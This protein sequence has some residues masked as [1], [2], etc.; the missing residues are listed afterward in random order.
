VHT[1]APN[2]IPYIYIYTYTYPYISISIKND[3]NDEVLK[4]SVIT[5]VLKH[6]GA[7]K[8]KKN[9]EVLKH[10]V[11]HVLGDVQVDIGPVH[12]LLLLVVPPDVR[13]SGGVGLTSDA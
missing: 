2:H 10:S 5:E 7:Q 12:A 13:P 9:D 6:R 3:K 1:R 11:I 8:K 4:H